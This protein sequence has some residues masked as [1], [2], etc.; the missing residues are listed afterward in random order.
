MRIDRNATAIVSD[1]QA[2]ADTQMHF[3]PAGV[4]GNSLIH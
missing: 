2:V 4:A 1:G 3:D